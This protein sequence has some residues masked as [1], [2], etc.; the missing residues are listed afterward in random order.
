MPGFAC[1]VSI[2]PLRAVA[3]NLTERLGAP[4]NAFGNATVHTYDTDQYA[5]VSAT[6]NPQCGIARDGAHTLL[7][8]GEPFDAEQPSMEQALAPGLLARCMESGPEILQGLDSHFVAVYWDGAKDELTVVVD[9]HGGEKVHFWHDDHT[10]F[11]ATHMRSFLW[12]ERIST[13]IRE[14]SVAESMCMGHCLEERTLFRDVHYLQGARTLTWRQGAVTTRRYWDFPF[15]NRDA[16]DRTSE[17][18]V[19][20]LHQ[21][22]TES[23]RRRRGLDTTIPLSGGLDARSLI[24]GID[25]VGS[26]GMSSSFTMGTRGSYD[27]AYGRQLANTYG[28]QHSTVPIPSTF[29]ADFAR[30]GMRRTEGGLIGHTYWRMASD[31]YIRNQPSHRVLMNGYWG[32]FHH[33]IDVKPEDYE[34]TLQQRFE[35]S[36]ENNIFWLQV[37][38]ESLA[39]LLRPECARRLDRI[40]HATLWKLYGASKVE[41][42]WGTHNNFEMMYIW[43][44]RFHRLLKDYTDEVSR[45]HFPYCDLPF[46]EYAAKMPPKLRHNTNNMADMIR[47]YYPRA[48]AVPHAETGLPLK[49]GRVRTLGYKALGAMQFKVI[50]KVTMGRIQYR[51]RR[52]LVHYAH[53]VRTANRSFF[54]DLLLG[55]PFFEAYFEPSAVRGYVREWLDSD[56]PN[57]GM[58]YNLATLALF[59]RYMVRDRGQSL[60]TI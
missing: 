28:V 22:L 4:L 43:P 40:N 33:G 20:D 56:E 31:A 41:D 3:D 12:H 39:P 15:E 45:I 6:L 47:K 34:L 36:Y 14:E 35:H 42:I 59:E 7:L 13:E 10:L 58:I 19:D 23:L 51:N 26:V 16:G 49:S 24:A 32:D 38:E 11:I 8:F 1:A 30:E 18:V 54:E 9:R 2:D 48:A 50:P 57:F 27:V 5:L 46:S 17:D 37:R 53:W 25:E 44:R 21:L 52:A 29:F 60:I 55:E